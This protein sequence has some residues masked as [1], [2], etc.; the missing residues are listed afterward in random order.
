MKT[1]DWI[2]NFLF[3][4]GVRYIFTIGGAANLSLLDSI[5][6]DGRINIICCLH[7]QVCAMS[8]LAYSAFNKDNSIGVCLVTTGPGFSNTLTGLASAFTD[9][10]PFLL[11]SGQV[12][13]KDSIQY[14]RDFKKDKFCNPIKLRQSGIQE[15]NASDIST[16]I[17]KKSFFIYDI[18]TVKDVF[19]QSFQIM[20]GGRKGPVHL[21]I[22]GNIFNSNIC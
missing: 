3:E 4:K 11:I 10:I 16:P 17:T 13:Y 2:V 15:I 18:N 19:K 12:N 1:T 14:K 7:E 22:C 20:L 5:K 6:K 8:A 9:S 21:D